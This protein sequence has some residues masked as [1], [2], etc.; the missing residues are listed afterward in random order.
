MSTWTRCLPTWINQVTPAERAHVEGHLADCAA[1]QGELDGLRRTVTLLRALPRVPV[2]RAFT[3][4]EAQVGIR[5]PETQPVWVGWARG[6]AAVT[7]IV[8]VAVVAVSLLNRPSW[9]P[10]ATVARNRAGCRGCPAGGS[11][12]RTG[13]ERAARSVLAKAPP[14]RWP[15]PPRWQSRP[16]RNR[17][18]W[19]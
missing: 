17:Q 16:S 18:Q 14:P 6:L 12:R 4:S 9:Q 1:C 7:A 19:R 11:T 15:N 5:R 13:R 2:P 3:L 8:L 10:A